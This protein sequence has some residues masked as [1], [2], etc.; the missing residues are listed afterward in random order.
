MFLNKASEEQLKVIE[1][2]Q[3]NNVIV[4]SVA[5]SG[6]TT[7]N[8]H[9][10]NTFIDSNILL[11]TYNSKLKLETRTKVKNLK[12]KNLEI[13]SYH[14]FC[15]KYYSSKC[16]NDSK[17]LK[18]LE[19]DKT[20]KKDINYDIIILD[21][22]QD[23]NPTFYEL[24]C[25]IYKDNKIKAKICILGDRYQSIYD[26]NY[27]DNRYIILADQ[28]F[29]FNN[30]QWQKTELNVSYRITKEMSDFINHCMLNNNRIISKKVSNN[31]PRYIICDTFGPDY[32]M[33][34]PF[35]EVKYY[36]DLGYK[37]EEIFIL[38]PSIKNINSPIRKLENSIKVNIKNI[39]IFVP[40]SDDEKLD[41]EVLQDKLVFS[42]FHQSKGLERKVVIVFG[43]DNMY[44]ELFKKDIDKN[45]CPNELY[46]ATTRGSERLTLI[47]HYKNDYLPFLNQEVLK[48]YTEL[49]INRKLQVEPL[50]EGKTINTPVTTLIRNL[51]RKTIEE[52]MKYLDITTINEPDTKIKIPSIT[53]QKYGYESVCEINGIAIPSYI[54]YKLKKEMTIYNYLL[55]TIDKNEKRDKL[56]KIKINDLRVEDL[57]YIANRWSSH[58]SGYIH[59]TEQINNYDWLDEEILQTFENNFKLLNISPEAE[60]EKLYTYYNKKTNRN[61]IGYIDCLD[62][63]N[64]FEFKCVNSLE[65]EH[66]LQLAI[67]AYLDLVNMPEL[68]TVNLNDIIVYEDLEE[69]SENKIKEEIILDLN[70]INLEQVIYNKT[71]Y[72]KNKKNYYLYNI[73][74][75][76]LLKIDFDYV[77]LFTMIDYLITSKYENII[78]LQNEEFINRNLFIKNKMM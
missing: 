36:L 66:I 58:T 57:L 37:P 5:G 65:S 12:I 27:A 72:E 52:C 41:S 70:K 77:K 24:I 63:N 34:R 54:E 45:M 20:P 44:F 25:K 11:L 1:L 8:L 59:K 10:A 67:Y 13:H 68:K 64:M 33:T 22:A 78:K 7:C 74:S 46:V 26:F 62:S 48:D 17:L 31:K 4:D 40:L 50:K 35:L 21:E 53:K 61:I 49:E 29:N 6:K 16:H 14:S 18:M 47:H 2:L 56:N 43:F 75:G 42:S 39:P 73:F 30:L 23:I 38:S 76:E 32:N 60:F 55:N 19:K 71:F 3:D 9:I 51:P 15:V 28:I 69:K